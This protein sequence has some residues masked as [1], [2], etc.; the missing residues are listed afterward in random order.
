MKVPY[1]EIQA[2]GALTMRDMDDWDMYY[3][4]PPEM[5]ALD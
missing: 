4:R 2:V 3:A 5:Q 1:D